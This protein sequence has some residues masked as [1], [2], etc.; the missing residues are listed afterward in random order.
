MKDID[1]ILKSI[2]E[3]CNA[4]KIIFDRAFYKVEERPSGKMA[5]FYF[6]RGGKTYGGAMHYDEVSELNIREEFI[7]RVVESLRKI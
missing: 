3:S 4:S 1:K 2:I 6:V 5:E 7:I